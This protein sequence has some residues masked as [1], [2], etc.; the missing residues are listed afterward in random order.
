VP[1]VSV[2]T[3]ILKKRM[4]FLKSEEWVDHDELDW[5]ETADAIYRIIR[6]A[7]KKTQK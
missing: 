1:E 5:N 6:Y 4:H 7:D 2:I 3:K